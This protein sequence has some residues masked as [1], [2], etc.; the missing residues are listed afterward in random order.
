MPRWEPGARARL[1]DAALDLFATQGYEQTSVAD[2]AAAAGVTE[3]TFFRHFTDKR[4]VLFSDGHLLAEPMLATLTDPAT[5]TNDPLQAML[6]ALTAAGEALDARRDLVQRRHAVVTAHANLR[7][8][9]LLKLAGLAN[10]AAHA[11]RARGV[12][13]QDVV[14]VAEVSITLFH[15]AFDRWIGAPAAHP[16]AQDLT[17][18]FRQLRTVT[19]ASLRSLPA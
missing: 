14:V 12:A 5:S 10:D 7:E 6:T 3:R 19:T 18:A 4:E 9:E 17:T 15:V 2:I 8:R 11:L 13:E 16:F 1:L